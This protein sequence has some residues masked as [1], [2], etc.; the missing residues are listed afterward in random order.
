MAGECDKP[1]KDDPPIKG[2]PPGDKGKDEKG[3]T[4]K[5]NPPAGGKGKPQINKI[6][7]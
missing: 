2:S 3:K 6:E 1:K 5:G 7:T 4:G